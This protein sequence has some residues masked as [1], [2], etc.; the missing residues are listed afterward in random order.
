VRHGGGV[1]QMSRPALKAIIARR[2]QR[3]AAPGGDSDAR[4]AAAWEAWR[5]DARAAT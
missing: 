1:E 5:L 2:R 3:R 4:H